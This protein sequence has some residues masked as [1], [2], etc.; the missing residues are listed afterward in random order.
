[1]TITS[2]IFEA[3]LKCP[4]KCFLR[5]FGKTGTGNAYADWTHAQNISYQREGIARLKEGVASHEC[6]TG[7][8]DRQELKSAK[9]HLAIDIKAFAQNVESTIH[10]VER[11]PGDT[12][13]KPARFIPIRFV[14][15]N[16]LSRH[17]KLLLAFDAFVLSETLCLEVDLGKIIY[18]DNLVTVRV[19]TSA[20]DGEVQKIN[21]KIR[22][23]LSS[24]A[25]PDLI[26]NRHCAE[27]EFQ[28]RCRQKAIEED[29]L[30]LLVGITEDERNRYRSKGIFTVKQLSYTF[31]PRRTLEASEESCEAALPRTAGARDTGEHCLHPRQSPAPHL[32]GPGVF[33]HRGHP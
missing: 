12:P 7:P 8:L 16:R 17:D 30:S 29:D 21:T 6:V 28:K 2:D 23:L 5:A 18:G 25:P 20:L 13:G 19:K 4:T 11:V 32:E 26:L 27:C 14:F 33:G 10:A 15:T 24:Q 31:R 22:A 3:Y 9:W 1:M